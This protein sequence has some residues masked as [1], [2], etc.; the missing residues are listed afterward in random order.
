MTD[1]H[2]Y[3]THYDRWCISKKY[4]KDEQER[5][6]NKKWNKEYQTDPKGLKSRPEALSFLDLFEFESTGNC[7]E[8]IYL[9]IDFE[10]NNLP[11]WAREPFD[12][13]VKETKKL[14]KNKTSICI[15][16]SW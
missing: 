2:Q 11:E 12:A 13:I 4:G 16:R 9:D 14:L 15:R 10:D 5:I 8:E 7:Q 1:L 3:A 6:F